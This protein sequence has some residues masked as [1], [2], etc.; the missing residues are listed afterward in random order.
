MDKWPFVKGL[1]STGGGRAAQN[2]L[3]TRALWAAGRRLLFEE[4]ASGGRWNRPGLYR[5]LGHP[6]QGDPLRRKQS[7]AHY[8]PDA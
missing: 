6:R 1:K 5:L 7:A 8:V 4:L 3:Q 2:D